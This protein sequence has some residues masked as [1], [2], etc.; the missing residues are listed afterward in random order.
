MRTTTLGFLF[1][2]TACAP[3]GG[4]F[5]NPGPGSG[6][7]S[8]SN[9][10]KC[11]Q[12]QSVS[13]NWTMNANNDITSDGNDSLPSGCYSIDGSLTLTGSSID[14]VSKLGDIRE[15]VD[16]VIDDTM[17]EK[18]DSMSPIHVTGSVTINH[19][20][21]L[22]DLTNLDFQAA[23]TLTGITITYNRLPGRRPA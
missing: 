1:S 11:D 5:G 23:D 3:V 18:I 8:G 19:N 22:T 14:S 21:V 17:L 2:I 20:D 12:M 13:G 16:L 7:G 9:T 6:S 4:G 10:A 15:V